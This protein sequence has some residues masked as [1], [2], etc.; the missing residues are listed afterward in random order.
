MMKNKIVLVVL[1]F[2]V[3]ISV[4][5]ITRN[6]LD[7]ERNVYIAF[8]KQFE[9]QPDMKNV[10]FMSVITTCSI[11]PNN[12]KKAPGNLINNFKKANDKNAELY[13]LSI[14]SSMVNVV[15]WQDTK[16]Y[17]DMPNTLNVKSGKSIILISQLGF[18]DEKNQ[19]L[20]C[21]NAGDTSFIYVFKKT[22]TSQWKL[23]MESRI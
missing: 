8:F 23:D 11:S 12:I 1:L 16:R 10:A 7:N 22:N 14:F 9:R 3:A 5:I 2:V 20:L 21:I 13:D 4:V 17:K 19:A 18:N 6:Y 15:G